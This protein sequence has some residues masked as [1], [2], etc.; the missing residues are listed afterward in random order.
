MEQNGFVCFAGSNHFR[1][2]NAKLVG[3]GA[4]EK[5]LILQRRVEARVKKRADAAGPMAHRAVGV[6]IGA[7]AQFQRGGSVRDVDEARVAENF[8]VVER[9]VENSEMAERVKLVGGDAVG[10]F[11]TAVELA[12]LDSQHAAGRGRV[13][14]ETILSSGIKPVLRARAGGGFDWHRLGESGRD[15]VR[16][17]VVRAP[18]VARAVN[19]AVRVAHEDARFEPA[20]DFRIRVVHRQ[21]KMFHEHRAGGKCPF[22]V[23]GKTD[24]GVCGN[25]EPAGLHRA[26][27]P[28]RRIDGV[29]NQKIRR[30]QICEVGEHAGFREQFGQEFFR[31]RRAAAL[32]FVNTSADAAHLAEINFAI[33]VRAERREAGVIRA[34]IRPVALGH[35]AEQSFFGAASWFRPAPRRCASRCRRKCI[36]RRGRARIPGRDKHSRR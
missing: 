13:A 25:R 22:A 10:I 23:R 6:E 19:V 15:Q 35:D 20:Q 28:Q 7:D 33:G 31:R 5:I 26:I 4:V 24:D 2:G 8:P 11:K 3:D 1:A 9:G 30:L 27:R 17:A 14:G 34:G 16:V 32:Q 36:C 12:C 18:F 29:R 21:F